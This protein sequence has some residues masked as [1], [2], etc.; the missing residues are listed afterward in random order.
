MMF[1]PE[2]LPENNE[3]QA[4]DEDALSFDRLFT[5]E[6]A[7]A[8]IPQVK[9]DFERI[10]Q[11]LGELKDGMILYKRIQLHQGGTLDKDDEV[12][13]RKREH[14]EARFEHWVHHFLDQGILLRDIDRGLIDFPYQSHAGDF[15]YLCWQLGEDGLFYFHPV[16]E[17]FMG[18]QPISLLPE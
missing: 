9:R 13:T 14:F 7:A 2:D 15:Y 10:H 4:D 5:L 1:N 3:I 18:R 8:L 12:F 6:E 17:G 11:E 16:E